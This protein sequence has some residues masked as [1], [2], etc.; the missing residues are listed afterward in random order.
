[1]RKVFAILIVPM[2][3]LATGARAAEYDRPPGSVFAVLDLGI[4]WASAKVETSDI[5]VA[6][7]DAQA[8]ATWG[9]RIGTALS[10]VVALGIDYVGYKSVEDQP[11]VFDRIESEY[12]IIGPSLAWYPFEGGLYARGLIGW[13]GV[14]FRIE[15]GDTRA[16]AAEDALGLAGSIGYEIPVNT[17]LSLGA[18]VDYVWMNVAEVEVADGIGGTEK[19][20]FSF[21]AWAVSAFVLLNY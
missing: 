14:D 18:E 1:M 6:E 13:G 7:S 4:S 9:F 16:R 12:W 17:L 8:G 5:T 19:A 15:D 20:D 3:L 2:L 11:N 21:S 10:E